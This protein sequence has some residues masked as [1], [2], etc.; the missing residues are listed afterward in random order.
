LLDRFVEAFNA[1]DLNRLTAMMRQDATSEMLG[2]LVEYGRDAIGKSG[3]GVLQRTFASHPSKDE[4]WAERHNFKSE[5]IIL[6]R[7]TETD[8]DVVTSMLRL[9]ERDGAIARLRYYFFCPETLTEVC[10]ELGLPVKT[11]GYRPTWN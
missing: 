6:F 11:N 1:R 3:K 2:M 9:E 4:W 5:P 8:R 7:T 10:A